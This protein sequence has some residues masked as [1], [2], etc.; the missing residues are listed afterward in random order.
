MSKKAESKTI[1]TNRYDFILKLGE[2]GMGAVYKV[3]DRLTGLLVAL[4]E[5]KVEQV[6]KKDDFETLT[7]EE[8]ALMNEFQILSSLR[9]PNIVSVLDYGLDE[10]MPYFTMELLA[11]PQNLTEF[12]NGKS[13]AIKIHMPVQLLQALAY[14]HHRNIIHRDLKPANILIDGTGV[15]KVLDFGIALSQDYL[16]P[17]QDSL[18]GTL[19]YLAPEVLQGTPV[20]FASDLYAFG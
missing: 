5:I 12:T 19:A 1:K 2:G 6:R 18:S 10:E 20:S 17:A 3:V 13:R 8:L 11:A 7:E 9:H 4:K 15:L 16:V 14:L